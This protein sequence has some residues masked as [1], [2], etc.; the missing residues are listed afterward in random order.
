MLASLEKE[1]LGRSLAATA[2]VYVVLNAT[3]DD[4]YARGLSSAQPWLYTILLRIR[5]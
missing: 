1:A 3:D 4:I 5:Q 2:S